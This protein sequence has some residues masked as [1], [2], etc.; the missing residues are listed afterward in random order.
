MTSS[1]IAP[2][3]TS[4]PG[5]MLPAGTLWLSSVGMTTPAAR[6]VAP[7]SAGTAGD[8]IGGDL[9]GYFWIKWGDCGIGDG[10]VLPL[11]PDGPV[12]LS[13][14]AHQISDAA[15]DNDGVIEAGDLL[16]LAVSVKNS[17]PSTATDV[18]V[19]SSS[20]DS[21]V[22]VID[23][24]TSLPDIASE[25]TVTSQPSLLAV[26]IDSTV[27][28]SSRL[29]FLLQISCTQGV[30]SGTFHDYLG[31]CDTIFF[32]D[33]EWCPGGWTHGGTSDNW[34]CGQPVRYSMIDADTAHSGLRVWGTGLG[35]GYYP[36]ANIYLE[37][38]VIN[39]ADLTNTRLQYYRWL[40]CEKGAWDHARIRVN[41]NLVWEND[42]EGDHVD[43]KWTYHDIDI[44]AFA[45]LNSSVKIR[46]ELQS[47]YGAELGG[48]NIDDLAITGI[49]DHVIG[50]TDGDGVQD[51]L[52][53]C[54]TLNNPDQ[55]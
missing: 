24:V 37:S 36:G 41:G 1:I 26:M 49:S 2:V 54:P 19:D 17:G 7:G 47:D 32:D 28:A 42:R 8:Q 50:D 5:G 35:S 18:S 30:F 11:Y 21:G 29:D 43:L 51:P 31:H 33:M 34:Q 38:P 23:S 6:A 22:H 27:L 20:V 40:S 10:V 13:F 9:G 4:T 52:D 12:T 39:C 16:G 44:S 25:E 45:D 46:F 15:G 48:W 3:A 14:E 55:H 53:N